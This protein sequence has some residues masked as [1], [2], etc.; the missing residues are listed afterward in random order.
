MYNSDLIAVP[1]VLT[2][3]R[4][5]HCLD[6]FSLFVNHLASLRCVLLFI[7]SFFFSWEREGMR[8]APSRLSAVWRTPSG[9]ANGPKAFGWECPMSYPLKPPFAGVPG[10]IPL[11]EVDLWARYWVELGQIF[12]RP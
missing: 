7:A 9:L 8:H 2:L 1:V 5:N 12:L 6:I 3:L 10:C 11:C 4:P